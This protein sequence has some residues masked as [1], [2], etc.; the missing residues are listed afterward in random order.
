VIKDKHKESSIFRLSNFLLI[1]SNKIAAIKKASREHE[2]MFIFDSSNRLLLISG[3]VAAREYGILSKTS[4]S[5]SNNGCSGIEDRF[6]LL[7]M[8]FRAGVAA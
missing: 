8:P 1:L 2:G 5:D 6:N 4:S 3:F 7:T